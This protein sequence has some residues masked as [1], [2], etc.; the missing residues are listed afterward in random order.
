MEG[1]IY[2]VHA[3]KYK[4]HILYSINIHCVSACIHQ[5]R[6]YR[7]HQITLIQTHRCLKQRNRR[8]ILTSDVQQGRMEKESK[9]CL[10]LKEQ[11]RLVSSLF[12]QNHVG[13]LHMKLGTVLSKNTG[14]K[15]PTSASWATFLSSKNNWNSC[16]CWTLDFWYKSEETEDTRTITVIC[17]CI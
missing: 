10:T 8:W 13:Q 4:V 9:Q 3:V 1:N 15:P 7:K 2:T 16:Y 12:Y 14:I 11:K 17:Y 5:A 6:I